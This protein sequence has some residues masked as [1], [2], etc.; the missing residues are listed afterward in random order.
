MNEMMPMMTN[1]PGGTVNL[2]GN[3]TIIHTQ[4]FGPRNPVM[5]QMSAMMR[6][7]NQAMQQQA[8]ALEQQKLMLE[9]KKIDMFDRMANAQ[10]LPGQTPNDN[11]RLANNAPM[12]TL[13]LEEKEDAEEAEY[14]VH[15]V[16]VVEEDEGIKIPKPK[17]FR[18]EV[19][20]EPTW[21]IKEEQIFYDFSPN[22]DY[23]DLSKYFDKDGK[24]LPA[25]RA[26]MDDASLNK[27]KIR[28]DYMGAPGV[29]FL[30]FNNKSNISSHLP[31]FWRHALG[32]IL[33][34][35]SRSVFKNPNIT[36]KTDY[37]I[38]IMDSDYEFMH[39]INVRPIHNL[40]TFMKVSAKE[41]IEGY[42]AAKDFV[43]W[44]NDNNSLIENN[45]V[46]SVMVVAE[47]VIPEDKIVLE[48]SP[49][50]LLST[51]SV[52]SAFDATKEFRIDM[53]DYINKMCEIHN[54][55]SN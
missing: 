9:A 45:R 13:S 19:H 54:I 28:C 40:S 21:E 33:D 43:N 36:S 32:Y 50:H 35:Y 8:L 41:Q 17:I 15:D 38:F 16:E 5:D 23:I 48:F 14:E 49:D 51:I 20:Q 47:P 18:E 29:I 6:L 46:K 39:I 42:K 2:F 1:D 24:I 55:H 30:K 7:Q 11:L 10:A 37:V 44:I 31:T 52:P 26:E 25:L 4:Q 53:N 22:A 3:M 27:I 34:R 12:A